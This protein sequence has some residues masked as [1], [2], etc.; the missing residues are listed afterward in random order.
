MC[1]DLL[2]R[3]P[4]SLR[5][6]GG[7]P[8]SSAPYRGISTPQESSPGRHSRLALLLH[9]PPTQGQYPVV[10]VTRPVRSNLLPWWSWLLLLR[11]LS[12]SG[13]HSL[14]P[15]SVVV[16][17][18]LMVRL[19]IRSSYFGGR[20]CPST[21][22]QCRLPKLPS[23]GRCCASMSPIALMYGCTSVQISFGRSPCQWLLHIHS[24]P[25]L[26]SLL[27]STLCHSR[28]HSLQLPSG[29]RCSTSTVTHVRLYIRSNVFR[30]P[31]TVLRP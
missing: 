20:F 18:S 17:L 11:S 27:C 26:W 15:P 7:A 9:L 21:P 28:S 23:G 10:R 19:Y 14:K 5:H 29:D 8:I 31:V 25:L 4:C 2:R 12:V 1:S 13:A 30:A 22:C 6:G 3:D 16:T 24:I